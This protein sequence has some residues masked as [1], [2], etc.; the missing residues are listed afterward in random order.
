M[1]VW[2]LSVAIIYTAA[3]TSVGAMLTYRKPERESK[4]R[5][6]GTQGVDARLAHSDNPPSI[7]PAPPLPICGRC[8]IDEDCIRQECGLCSNPIRGL[9]MFCSGPGT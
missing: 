6:F 5:R 4:D 1:R 3:A 7:G 2:T 9:G 8:F